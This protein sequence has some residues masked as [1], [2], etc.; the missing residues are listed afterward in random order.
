MDMAN[1]HLERIASAAQ[2]NS[3]KMQHHYLLREGL[4]G[5]QQ[6][7]LLKLVKMSGA[8]GS[9]G[10]RGVIK[11]Q[12]GLQEPQGEGSGGQEDK[13]EGAPGEELGCVLENELGNGKG[14]K[15]GMK[16]DG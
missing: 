5:Q 1:G 8:T 16:E 4:V 2:R 7:L 6:M 12:Q 15:D 3:C 13:T 14:V 11:D 10:V 9:G